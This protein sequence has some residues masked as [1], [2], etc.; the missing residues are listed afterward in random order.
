M[1]IPISERPFDVLASQLA[2]DQLAG[3]PTLGS[4][5][6][7]TEY[8]HD[9]PDMSAAAIAKRERQDDDWARRLGALSADDLT[10]DELID[11]DLVLMVLRGRAVMRS[12]ADWRRSPDH[13]AGAALSGVF[14]LLMHR[15][16]PAPELATAV[17]AR[18]AAT[19]ELLQQG[20][21]N[22]DPELAHPALLRRGLGMVRAGAGYARSVAGE[23]AQ[24]DGRAEVAAAGELAAAA[25]EG[26]AGHLEALAERAHG[27]WAIGEDRY[28]A[29]LR[30]AEGLGYG[31]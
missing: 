21:D 18:L 27:E 31:T 7:L 2:A 10:A 1:P 13:Y 4:G 23:F 26:F 20:I 28:D 6:G 11:R 24:S 17:A 9:L 14:G 19:P 29:L 8:D 3:S 16:R 5:L 25:F 12:F 22:L 15:L 30:E